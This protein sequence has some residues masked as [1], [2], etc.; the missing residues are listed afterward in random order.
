MSRFPLEWVGSRQDVQL[1]GDYVIGGPGCG[2]ISAFASGLGQ[3]SSQP[4]DLN[5]PEHVI[6]LKLALF[7]LAKRDA[8]SFRNPDDPIKERRYKDM[9]LDG[10]Y[11]A[12]WDG[13][14]ADE[15]VMA[16]SRYQGD[17]SLSGPFMQI[18]GSRFGAGIVGGPQPTAQGLEVIAGAVE[19]RLGGTPKMSN[20][21]GWRG[22]AI[23]PPSSISGPD[24]NAVVTPVRRHGPFWDKDGYTPVADDGVAEWVGIA[25]QVDQSLV[26]CWQQL[27]EAPTEE[28]RSL[29]LS[30]CLLPQ[31]EA[32][33][34]AALQANAN[35]PD[36]DC[37]EGY[38][39]DRANAECRK[40][41]D[42]ILPP[43]DIEIS[44]AEARRICI[45]GQM[46]DHGLSRSEAER[47]CPYAPKGSPFWQNMGL[48]LAVGGAA[49]LGIWYLTKKK[50]RS[51]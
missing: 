6:E 44:K 45:E 30:D 7:E 16:I 22:G 14:T 36:P 40:R 9:I 18:G 50:G 15:F 3:A 29:V 20:Y 8:D 33:H 4:Y 24:E 51:R 10:R 43:T 28:I 25:S 5:V 32:H 11:A 42:I 48:A 12:S 26:Q 47:I 39:Y 17:S 35:Q 49:G 34:T 19:Q 46:Q 1:R 41:T 21:L 31:R 13:A 27:M 23:P 2:E 38:F 37:G